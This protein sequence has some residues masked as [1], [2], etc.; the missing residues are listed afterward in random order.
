MIYIQKKMA[1][2]WPFLNCLT[3]QIKVPYLIKSCF[4]VFDGKSKVTEKNGEE[5][6]LASINNDD[7]SNKSNKSNPLT[8]IILEEKQRSNGSGGFGEDEMSSKVNLD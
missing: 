3:V 7:N 4:V 5:D 6:A 2:V 1:S 8:P